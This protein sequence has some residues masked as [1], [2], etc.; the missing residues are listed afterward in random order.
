MLLILL[1]VLL[2]LNTTDIIPLERLLRYWPVLLIVAGRLSAV[3]AADWAR[4]E[5]ARDAESA[6]EVHHDQ[7]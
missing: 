3:R 7:Q 4:R 5:A 2:L 6:Q 1:G